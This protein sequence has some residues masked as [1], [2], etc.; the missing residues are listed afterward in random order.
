MFM[1]ITDCKE[2]LVLVKPASEISMKAV[3][4]RLSGPRNTSTAMGSGCVA[5]HLTPLGVDSDFFSP[6]ILVCLLL[7][8]FLL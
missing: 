3:P 4:F 5:C 1:I 7:S 8:D 2:E 6:G